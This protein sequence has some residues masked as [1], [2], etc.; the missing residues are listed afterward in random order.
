MRVTALLEKSSKAVEKST[1]WK[2]LIYDSSFLNPDYVIGFLRP[3]KVRGDACPVFTG[4]V[5]IARKSGC[6]EILA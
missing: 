5:A 4:S 1:N 2:T 6:L 3:D